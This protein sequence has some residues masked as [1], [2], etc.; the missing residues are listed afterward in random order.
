MPHCH[1]S[2]GIHGNSR[3][4]AQVRQTYC[5]TKDYKAS[6][7]TRLQTQQVYECICPNY[8]TD[9][10]MVLLMYRLIATIH[11]ID[12]MESHFTHTSFFA[13]SASFFLKEASSP[14]KNDELSASNTVLPSSLS[15][16]ESN[17]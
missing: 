9:A 2:R 15:Y 16:L 1:P 5:L 12:N 13:N 7:K 14:R 11:H 10:G 4:L 8:N 17:S 3:P 6:L